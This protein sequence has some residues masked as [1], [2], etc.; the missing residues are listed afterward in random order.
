MTM[1]HGTAGEAAV[2]LEGSRVVATL[3][4]RG[5]VA[6]VDT[7]RSKV[8]RTGSRQGLEVRLYRSWA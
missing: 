5:A 1:P 7:L 4:S 2:S 3:R 6:G 8:V